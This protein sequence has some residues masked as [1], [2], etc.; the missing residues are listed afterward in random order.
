MKPGVSIAR[1]AME[2]DLNPNLLR[3]WITRHQKAHAAVSSVESEFERSRTVPNGVTLPATRTC[4]PEVPSP[5]VP[6]VQEPVTDGQAV[7]AHLKN[8]LGYVNAYAHTIHCGSSGRRE[9]HAFPI[10]A[11]RCRWPVRVHLTSAITFT[12][13]T[14]SFHSYD[15]ASSD[16]HLR[17]RSFDTCGTISG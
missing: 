7:C 6:V 3:G 15:Q 13:G 16:Q 4:A 10:W 5:F 8:K 17:Y 12:G 11:H 14:R 1:T 2:F 9:L